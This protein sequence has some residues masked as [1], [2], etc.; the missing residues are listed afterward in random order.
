MTNKKLSLTEEQCKIRDFGEAHNKRVREEIKEKSLP[1]ASKL[2]GETPISF[3]K[4]EWHREEAE[5]GLL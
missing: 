3:S 4:E 1:S 2:L 5:V